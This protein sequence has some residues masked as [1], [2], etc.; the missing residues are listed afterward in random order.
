MGRWFLSYNSQDP[1][2]QQVQT[3]LRDLPGTDPFYAP[4]SLRAGGY[5]LPTLA[6]EINKADAFILLIGEK[7]LGPWQVPE[8]YEAFD[9]RVKQPGFPLVVLLLQGQPAPGLPFLRQLHWVVG[10]DLTAEAVIGKI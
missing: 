3:R 7:G 10:P 6:D 5:W 9:R 2:H 8:Y 1:L 4:A